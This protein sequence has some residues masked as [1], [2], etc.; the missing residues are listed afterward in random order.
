VCAFFRLTV[1]SSVSTISEQLC[2]YQF[3]EVHYMP[4]VQ[5]H[6]PGVIGNCLDGRASCVF[7]SST[8]RVVRKGNIFLTH[9]MTAVTAS[10]R[11]KLFSMA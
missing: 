1:T 4:L 8:C 3:L 6:C 9:D 11:Y 7:C 2:A 5:W 10:D